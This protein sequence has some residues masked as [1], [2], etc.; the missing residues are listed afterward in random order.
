MLCA[1][2]FFFEAL[3][4]FRAGLAGLESLTGLAALAGVTLAFACVVFLAFSPALRD[5][6]AA[7]FT[8]LKC[9]RAF[10][11]C[12]FARRTACLACE[13]SLMSGVFLAV[14]WVS[15]QA[16]GSTRNKYSRIS[17]I[18]SVQTPWAIGYS[19]HSTL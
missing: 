17:V 4:A 12:A 16:Y 6:L 10:F 9:F 3:G 1:A 14:T 7:F 2:G 18:S 8:A 5:S 11:S 13:S 19:C 15:L